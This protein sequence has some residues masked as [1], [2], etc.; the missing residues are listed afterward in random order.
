MSDTT[1]K[2]RVILGAIIAVGIAMALLLNLS[3]N[4]P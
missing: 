4:H 2:D 1:W 3:P